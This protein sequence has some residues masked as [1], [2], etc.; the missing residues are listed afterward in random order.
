MFT[1]I[2]D[3]LY[4]LRSYEKAMP[5]SPAW[6]TR[7]R[8][9]LMH[10]DASSFTSERT[11]KLHQEECTDIND[12]VWRLCVS[13]RPLNGVTKRFE[14]P[15]PRCFD[16]IEHFGDFRRKVYFISLDARSGYHQIQVRKI[17]QE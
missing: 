17:D 10:W 7:A 12:C 13:Y 2:E 11:P 3:N 9:D 16:S 14:Y 15:I 5:R 4:V 8:T 6:K 1:Y